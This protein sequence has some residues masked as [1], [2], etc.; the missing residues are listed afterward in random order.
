[1]A[2]AKLHPCKKCGY[3]AHVAWYGVGAKVTVQCGTCKN[4][5][6]AFD[7]E[8]DAIACW[9][10][11]NKPATDDRPLTEE[12]KAAVDVDMNR[13]EVVRQLDLIARTARFVAD[14]L[15]T[16]PPCIPFAQVDFTPTTD[17]PD[18]DDKRILHG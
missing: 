14:C 9:N 17:T 12:E 10:L 4:K 16:P 11:L 15:L 18:I 2:K 5:L 8:S 3:S 7:N 1:M 6:P 13:P